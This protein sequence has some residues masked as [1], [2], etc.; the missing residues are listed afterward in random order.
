M[1][2]ALIVASGK[3]TRLHENSIPKQFIKVNDKPLVCYTIEAFQEHKDIDKIV[4]VTSK[5]YKKEMESICDAYNFFK[6]AIVVEGGSSRQESVLNGLKALKKLNV[7][8][9]DIVLI[10][11]GVRALI[12]QEIISNNILGCQ[13]YNAVSTAI[14][15]TDTIVKTKGKEVFEDTLNREELIQ[16]QTP[17]SFKFKIIYDAHLN[18]VRSFTDDA[19]LVKNCN[20]DIHI[21]KGSFLNFKITYKEDLEL[22]KKI[23]A[24]RT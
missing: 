20:Q 23:I 19:S 21:V 17:Q 10:H 5:E 11:D 24:S 14:P 3:G 9:D 6:V 18:C 13:N 2:I 12:S 7:Q 16:V 15:A 8:D 22:F 4:I 1:N